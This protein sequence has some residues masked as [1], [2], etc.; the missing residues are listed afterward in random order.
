[1]TPSLLLPLTLAS[2]CILPPV[3]SA[4]SLLLPCWAPFSGSHERRRRLE[5]S[6]ARLLQHPVR[7]RLGPNTVYHAAF[8]HPQG[9]LC[10][11]QYT[12]SSRSASNRWRKSKGDG[13]SR[14]FSLATPTLSPALSLARYGARTRLSNNRFDPY[15]RLFL[16]D[17][18][19]W[20]GERL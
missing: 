11:C 3:A 10:I 12:I 1:V 16:E 19:Y 9:T 13:E 5:G 14:V 6:A 8:E 2:H 17:V 7:T 15:P 18:K 20:W 4:L